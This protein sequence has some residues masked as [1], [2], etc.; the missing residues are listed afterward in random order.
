MPKSSRYPFAGGTAVI[1]GAAG[2]IGSALASQLAIRGSHLALVDK[3]EFGLAQLRDEIGSHAPHARITTHHLD[4]SQSD[5]AE[6]L[7]TEVIDAH[8]NPTLII[9][10]AGVALGGM[11]EQVSMADVDWLLSIN[12]RGTL[13]V[14]SAFLPHLQQGAHITNVSSLFGL[15][16]PVGNATY[17]A[18]KFAVRGFSIALREELKPRGIS[19]TSVHPGG[20]RT[21]IALSSRRGPGVSDE[22]WAWGQAEASRLLTRDPQAAAASILKA[23]YRRRPRDLIGPEA[24]AGD[25]LARLAPARATAVIGGL[26]RWRAGGQAPPVR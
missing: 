4:L 3:N 8:Q 23:I 9:N 1:T 22:Q 25:V 6:R 18:S 11:F 14:T 15:V 19:V 13:A 20:V 10:N 26:I 7:R 17:A 24:Y 16:A 12:L 5:A 2:G 21:S